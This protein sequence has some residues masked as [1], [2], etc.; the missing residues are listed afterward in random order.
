MKR[1]HP[2]AACAAWT[3]KATTINTTTTPLVPKRLEPTV[4]TNGALGQLELLER[5]R[6]R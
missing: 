1:H 3:L 5:P 2:F 4:R 6:E